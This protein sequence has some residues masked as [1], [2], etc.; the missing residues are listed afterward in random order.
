MLHISRCVSEE[1]LP[2]SNTTGPFWFSECSPGS[3]ITSGTRVLS[4]GLCNLQQRQHQVINGAGR[5]RSISSSFKS[6]SVRN[7]V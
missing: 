2:D 3:E 7:T 1:K 5:F 4:S 6:L